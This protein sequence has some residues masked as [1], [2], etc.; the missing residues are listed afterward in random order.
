M[1]EERMSPLAVV[2]ILLRAARLARAMRDT[3]LAIDLY[4]LTARV[5]VRAGLASVP[6]GD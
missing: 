3:M 2:E 1:I 5:A 4:D 6:A